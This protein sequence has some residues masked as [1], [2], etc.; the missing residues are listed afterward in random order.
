MEHISWDMDKRDKAL[1]WR[2]SWGGYLDIKKIM[3]TSRVMH[4]FEA[5]RTLFIKDYVILNDRN[6]S[7]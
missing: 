5:S 2:E 4:Y 6:P 7:R 3:D 1:F